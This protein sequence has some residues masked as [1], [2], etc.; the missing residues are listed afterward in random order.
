MKN[1]LMNKKLKD[2]IEK[3][4]NSLH[5]TVSMTYELEKYLKSYIIRKG[6]IPKE[7]SEFFYIDVK[8]KKERKDYFEKLKKFLYT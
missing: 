8:N 3:L 5:L 6:D 2:I 7:I 4:K 1:L